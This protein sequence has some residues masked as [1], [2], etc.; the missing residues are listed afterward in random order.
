M[1]RPFSRTAAQTGSAFSVATSRFLRRSA[2]SGRRSTH[3]SRVM[4]STSRATDDGST[5]SRSATSACVS[6]P[7]AASIPSIWHCRNVMPV[8]SSASFIA[9]SMA[10]AAVKTK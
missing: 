10:W 5:P 1:A 8:P 4:R 2:G 6:D 7:W 9:R 3:P